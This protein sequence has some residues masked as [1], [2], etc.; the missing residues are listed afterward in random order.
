MEPCSSNVASKL[1]TLIEQLSN[2][3]SDSI[4]LPLRVYIDQS[5]AEASAAKFQSTYQA[6]ETCIESII[7]EKASKVML[8]VEDQEVQKLIVSGVAAKMDQTYARFYGM[9]PDDAA[10]VDTVSRMAE[11]VKGEWGKVLSL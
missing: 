5:A 3:W 9:K 10:D 7:P 6:F 1:Q 8:W 4:I 11:R 2:L